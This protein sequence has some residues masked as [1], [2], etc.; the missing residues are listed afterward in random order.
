M[1]S[2]RNV[3]LEYEIRCT[4]NVAYSSTTHNAEFDV[5]MGLHDIS[6]CRRLTSLELPSQIHILPELACVSQLSNLHHITLLDSSRSDRSDLKL[7]NYQFRCACE[8]VSALSHVRHKGSDRPIL[9]PENAEQIRI[10]REVFPSGLHHYL[11]QEWKRG[12]HLAFDTKIVE[13]LNDEEAA[14]VLH[15]QWSASSGLFMEDIRQF[16]RIHMTRLSVCEPRMD[17]STLFI[18]MAPIVHKL[19]YIEL[20]AVESVYTLQTLVDANVP[21][22]RALDLGYVSITDASLLMEQLQRIPSL[23]ELVIWTFDEDDGKWGYP[24]RSLEEIKTHLPALTSY[25]IYDVR[26]RGIYLPME[27][28]RTKTNYRNI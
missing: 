4:Q 25:R 17:L 11:R 22:L 15:I 16:Q 6:A 5:L 8:V 23:I 20:H 19:E 7:T 2:E 28:F 3:C 26:M 24:W 10:M 14:H 9:F 27:I 18:G 1:A 13:G 21:N 12:H